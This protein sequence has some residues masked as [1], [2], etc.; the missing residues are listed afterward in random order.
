MLYILLGT[1]DIAPF[2]KVII[3]FQNS[4]SVETWSFIALKAQFL[5]LNLVKK[6]RYIFRMV[7]NFWG[8]RY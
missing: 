7:N 1:Y 4:E 3:Y 8:F 5:K 6:S 2:L